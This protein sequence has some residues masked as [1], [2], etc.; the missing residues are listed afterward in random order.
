M[1]YNT[2]SR[3]LFQW[4]N[5][6]FMV[7]FSA[8]ILFPLINLLAISLSSY[9]P[10]QRRDVLLM[11]KGFNVQ[12]YIQ[13]ISDRVF[14]HSFLN[15]VWLTIITTALTILIATCAGYALSSRHLR[16]PKLVL[17]FFLVPMYFSGGLI[18]TYL[19]VNTYLHL[20]DSYLALILPVV[21]SSF[22]IIIFRNNIMGLPKEIL[23]SA[24]VDGANDYHVLFRI[25]MPIII[26]TITAF[27]IINAVQH[28]N[29]WYRVMLYIKDSSKWTLQ[30]YLRNLLITV[31][32]P[33]RLEAMAAALD[34]ETAVHQDS[35][36]M[37]ALFITILP[38]LA[39]YPFCQR[40]FIH[41]VITGA[42]K[43]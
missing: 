8:I 15:T 3:K 41:G 20:A 38:I 1:I 42:V 5:N 16:H 13:I 39:I 28:W 23:E 36:E 10:V 11:P 29:E 22:Y 2:R 14:Q 4:C 37:A 26:P 6:V 31:L 40:F 17:F 25:V 35:Y 24:E 18:P 32:T 21:T 19:V 34:F 33:E 27:I 43:G 12:A 7:L 9:E 30:Y